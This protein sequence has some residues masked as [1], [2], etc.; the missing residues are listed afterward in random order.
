MYRWFTPDRSQG[1]WYDHEAY[2]R[3]R[4]R[5]F[6]VR[7]P[8]KAI[9]HVDSGIMPSYSGYVPGWFHQWYSANTEQ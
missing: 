2:D 7:L 3:Y 6:R 1:V 8:A 9:Y 5:A 4:K